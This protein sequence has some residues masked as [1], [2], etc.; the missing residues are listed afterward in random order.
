MTQDWGFREQGLETL[1]G[2]LGFWRPLEWGCRLAK[3]GGYREDN[4]GV[5]LNEATVEVG[6]PEEDLNIVDRFRSWLVNNCSNFVFLHRHS[7]RGNHK[8]Q[9]FYFFHVK[10]AFLEG[11]I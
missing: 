5:G 2:R 8:A 3:E 9:E 11:S 1:E 10:L 4:T 7:S 6:K